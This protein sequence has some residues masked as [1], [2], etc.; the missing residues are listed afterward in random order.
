MAAIF[1]HIQFVE[2]NQLNVMNNLQS[3]IQYE[4]K[5]KQIIKLLWKIVQN[6]FLVNKLEWEL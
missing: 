3:T 6:C 1:N 5:H 2:Q 4:N